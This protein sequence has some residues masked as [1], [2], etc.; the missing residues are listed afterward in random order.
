[1]LLNF[2]PEYHAA[3]MQRS[4]YQQLPLLPLSPE[5]ITELL[6]DLLGADRSLRRL[7]EL[8]QERTGGNPFFIEEIVQSLIET[9]A[10]AGTRGA[11]RL[12]TPA[13]EVGL[14]A[15]VQSVLAARIDRLPEREKRVLQTASVIG[16]QFSEPI[17]KRVA[18]LGDGDLPAAL[19][20]L[21]SAE[22]LY[23]EALYPEA[24]YAFKHPLTQEVA[25]RSQ[26][27]ERRARVH[28][29]VARAIEEIDS[30]KLGE[31]AALLAYHW[32]RAG[33]ARVAAKWHSRAA[34]WVGLNNPS[35]AL[36]HWGSVRQLLDTLPETPENLAERAAV[37]AQI[38]N[39]LGRL[40]DVEDQAI[41]LFREGR[42]LAARSGD[43]HVLSQILNAFGL[44]RLFA[45]A[46]AEALDPLLESIRL[47]DET[48][49]IG[50]RVAVRYG[51]SGAYFWDGRLRECLAVAEQGLAL[52]RGD[53]D[54]GADRVG[55]SPSLGLSLFHGA[56]L[57]LTGHPREGAAELDRVIELARTSQQLMPLG[58]SHAHHAFRCE[59]T[60]EAVPALA[61][62]R[63]AVDYTERTGNQAARSFA[64]FSLGLA[65]LLNG[66][67][68]DALE[69]LGTAL[70][71]GRERRL[72]L[73]EGY[74]L[75]AMA[76]AHLGLGD[77]AKALAIAE[78]AIAVSRPRGARLYEF[79][80][81][82]TRMRALREIHGVQA[83][84]EIEATLAEADAWL[85]MSGAKSYE[86][87]LHVERAELARLTGDEAS[88]QREL[89][90][91]HRLFV[92]IGAPIRAAEIAQKLAPL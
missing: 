49:D 89:R 86:P 40:G 8:I 57:S 64:Y 68:H 12:V 29:A 3:W 38:M 54:L 22:F 87:F 13:E 76:A 44:L 67:W 5:E 4:Y 58:M 92:E 26:L 70:T 88:R 36:R 84:S 53:L 71:I 47:A 72:S 59:V 30:G 1:M 61:H 91:A 43:P 23:E 73:I 24:E 46:V 17:L 19:H 55:F 6:G 15:T 77:R 80:A 21:T 60:G 32:E 90:E 63:E 9:G 82:L 18:S 20:A 7:R 33:E 48:E 39:H 83:T 65:N 81:L 27:A 42:E 35:E 14:P 2:R 25:Y 75:G 37:R 31:R 56:V 16:K 10:L 66:A 79:S 34:E 11:Y 28:G 41:S 69:V 74:A 78:E 52:A 51:L 62:G 85:E 50:L 45:G